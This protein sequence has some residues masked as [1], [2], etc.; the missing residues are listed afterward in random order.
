MTANRS[1]AT[2]TVEKTQEAPHQPWSLGL[3][4]MPAHLTRASKVRGRLSGS[5]CWLM[6]AICKFYKPKTLLTNRHIAIRLGNENSESS[7]VSWNKLYPV[8]AKGLR[9]IVC[10]NIRCSS[11][12]SSRSFGGF[13]SHVPEVLRRLDTHCF[14]TVPPSDHSLLGI[15][16]DAKE[17]EHYYYIWLSTWKRFSN[18][19]KKLTIG[20]SLFL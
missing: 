11:S 2:A 6:G 4:I 1:E 20:C 3:D 19:L 18:Y 14:R 10:P 5:K 8:D 13:C 12:L 16:C 17:K 15:C 9:R 7:P